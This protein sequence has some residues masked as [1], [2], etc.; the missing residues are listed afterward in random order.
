MYNTQIR[1][2]EEYGNI[3]NSFQAPHS[4]LNKHISRNRRFA[5]QVYPFERLKAIGTKHTPPSTT[6]H[7]RSSAA[8]SARFSTDSASCPKSP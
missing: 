4:I 5:T 7:W 6:S 3:T 1:S 2:D 8:D